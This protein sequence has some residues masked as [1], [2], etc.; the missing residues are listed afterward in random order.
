MMKNDTCHDT[1][2]RFSPEEIII[3]LKKLIKTIEQIHANMSK[4][5]THSQ[6]RVIFP[7]IKDGK[8]YT[9][10]EL[11]EMGCVTK[12]LVSRTIADL[13]RK[14]YVQRDKKSDSQDRNYKIILSAKGTELVEKKKLQ[15]KESSSKW[16]G[17]LTHEDMQAF[18]KVLDTFTGQESLI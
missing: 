14:G 10:H 7:I 16:V 3:K 8:G 17:K 15:M 6:M 2:P 11:A 13:E 12:G 9:M 4:E 1:R 18:M 5:I